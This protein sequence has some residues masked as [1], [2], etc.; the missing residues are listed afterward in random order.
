MTTPLLIGESRTV[1]ICS[2]PLWNQTD[3]QLIPG[4]YEMKARGTWVDF[5]IPCGP[6]GYR[7]IF[8]GTLRFPNASIFALIGAIGMDEANRFVIGEHL[9]IDISGIGELCC[10]ANDLLGWYWNNWGKLTLTVSRL[11]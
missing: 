6:N 5:Y 1:E 3:I 7:K 10:Y 8:P 2:R 4:S 9:R 11:S